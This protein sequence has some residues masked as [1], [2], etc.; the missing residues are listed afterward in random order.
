[1]KVWS[2]PLWLRFKQS[3]LSLKNVFGTPTEFKPT[4]YVSMIH[5]QWDT[6]KHYSV[7][8]AFTFKH[9]TMLIQNKSTETQVK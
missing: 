6:Q 4:G 2:L 3:Q 5:V 8:I 7:D 9:N 1:M